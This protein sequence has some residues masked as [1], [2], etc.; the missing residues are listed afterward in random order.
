[1]I[2]L[3]G[4]LTKHYGA[5][6][7]TDLIGKHPGLRPRNV[8]ATEAEK[9]ALLAAAPQHLRLWLLLC[10][11]L[12]IRSGTASRIGPRNYNAASRELRFTTKLGERLTLPVTAE[13]A[14]Y[15]AQC[16]PADP[17]PFVRRVPHPSGAFAARVGS[18]NS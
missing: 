16:D 8:T 4:W 3:L 5:P 7:L 18:H 1:M 10:S 6:D 2:R 9:Q 15:I 17:S 12:A 14:A 13:I 11:D